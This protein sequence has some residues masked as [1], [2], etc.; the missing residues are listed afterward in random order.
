MRR[1]LRQIVA[2]P[3][4]QI[5]VV[6]LSYRGYL[7]P[8]TFP[9]DVERFQASQKVRDQP[10]GICQKPRLG[11]K[12]PVDIA[13]VDLADALHEVLEIHAVEKVM[14]G[15]YVA[16]AFAFRIDNFIDVG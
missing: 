9:V 11:T 15:E 14:A 8:Q 1:I 16:S 13:I 10:L 5:E 3:G 7:L 4:G 6:N 12:M 2:I